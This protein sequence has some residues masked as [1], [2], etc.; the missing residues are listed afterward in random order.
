MVEQLEKAKMFAMELAREARDARCDEVNVMDLR[1]LS[2]VTSFFV[3]C[4]GTSDRQ[5]RTTAD[6]LMMY[7]KEH[8]EPVFSKSGLETATWILVDFVH[9]VVH[10]FTPEHRSY[11]DLELLWGDAPRIEWDNTDNSD[12]AE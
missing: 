12:P 1:G 9:V 5:M 3:V 11:Y 4:S 7:G 10:I 6:R 2:P 8:G